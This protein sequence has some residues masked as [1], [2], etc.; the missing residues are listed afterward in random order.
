MIRSGASL[1]SDYR[2][3]LHPGEGVMSEE[4]GAQGRGRVGIGRERPRRCIVD[5]GRQFGGG[6]FLP[7]VG[8][9]FELHRGLLCWAG[10]EAAFN[11]FAP[12][13][14]SPPIPVQIV[15]V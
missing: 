15:P 11:F 6:T 13:V 14:T 10:L 7:S 1:V 9:R 8:T 4:E 5:N 3:L 12:F 2:P